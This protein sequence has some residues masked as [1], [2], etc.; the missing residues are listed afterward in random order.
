MNIGTSGV[1]DNPA[2]WL[3]SIA[4]IDPDRPLMRIPGGKS[5]SYGDVADISG[6]FA[7]YLSRCG[8][9]AGDRVAAQINKSPEGFMLYLAC[10]HIGA[11]YVPLN[12]AYSKAEIEYFIQDSD[13]SMLVCVPES[14]NE[15]TAIANKF[16]VPVL[17]SLGVDGE[18][19][20][21]E[22]AIKCRPAD[23][24]PF[25]GKTSEVAAILYT[26]GTTGRSKGAMITRSALAHCAR[27]LSDIW[28]FTPGDILLHVLPVFHG[29]GLFIAANTVL[30]AG[31]QMI[32]TKRFDVDEI[33]RC[34][35]DA[36]V[37]MGVPTMYMRLLKH[38]G[39]S[40]NICDNLR[41]AVSGSAPIMRETLDAFREKTGCTILERYGL[42][43][44]LIVT[45]NPY[46]GTAVQGSV[47][48]PVPGV[49]VRIVDIETGQELNNV[50]KIG[51]IEVRGPGLFKGYW[52]NPEK[53]AEEMRSDGYFK[54]GD[55]G[56]F[57]ANDYLFIVGRDKDMIITGGYNVYPKEVEIAIDNMEG[58]EES[59]VIGLPHPDFGEAVT[60]IV[61]ANRESQSSE[62]DIIAVLKD[63]LAK[64]KCPK[65]IIF[66]DSLPRN[67]MGKIQK[68][69]LRQQYETRYQ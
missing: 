2:L 19:T 54:T 50:N 58:I 12:T 28:H 20:F 16:N 30:A 64:Y 62:A 27:I 51:K 7:A 61:I 13:P 52:K 5:Y 22:N 15:I 46:D 45:A 23:F 24:I 60:A 4:E 39:F 14:L 10:L 57:D 59:A 44:T 8:V 55:L 41:L 67:A 65:K 66:V 37:F 18:G 34:L 26:S 9:C 40:K 36:T 42:T 17:R 31:A 29:H 1:K 48:L 35:P 56:K 11:I 49:D 32:F 69:T 43:E 3:E 68:N 53:T 6:R 63:R 25:T 33:I 47:G 21:I 38:P